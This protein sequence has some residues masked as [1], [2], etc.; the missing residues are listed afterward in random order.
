ML[1]LFVFAIAIAVHNF[2][3]FVIN[4]DRCQISQP[5][6]G[7]YVL[8]ILTLAADVL[9]SIFLIQSY[10]GTSQIL[11]LVMPA[12]FKFLSGVEQIEMMFE[13]IFNLDL[14]I[15]VRCPHKI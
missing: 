4:G 7:F 11:L 13:L 12:T 6:F 1:S 9:Y 10:T 2:V 3:A 15:K 8:T 14:E 5:L